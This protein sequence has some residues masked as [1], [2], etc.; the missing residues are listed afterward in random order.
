[1]LDVLYVVVFIPNTSLIAVAFNW[2]KQMVHFCPYKTYYDV[3]ERNQISQ[4]NDVKLQYELV[5]NR[6]YLR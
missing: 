1:M 6:R 4:T 3:W 5:H 2:T